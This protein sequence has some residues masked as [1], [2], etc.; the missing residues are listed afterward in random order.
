MSLSLVRRPPCLA[1][2]TLQWVVETGS[3]ML[4]ATTTVRAEASSM[5]KPLEEGGG[6]VKTPGLVLLMSGEEVVSVGGGD[7]D[8]S[9]A[10]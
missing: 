7:G 2:P 6:G 1:P 3:P 8:A 9:S 5:L 10:V 4:E